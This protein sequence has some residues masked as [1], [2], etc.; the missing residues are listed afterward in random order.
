MDVGTLK[1][2]L[3]EYDECLEVVYDC[4]DGPDFVI[5]R[6]DVDNRVSPGGCGGQLVVLMDEEE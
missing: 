2:L 3:A 1:R 4:G 5:G 6:V